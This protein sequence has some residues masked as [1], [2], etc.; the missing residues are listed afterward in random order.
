M[1][2]RAL[3]LWRSLPEAERAR[4]TPLRHAASAE[5]NAVEAVTTVIADRY[6]AAAN[7]LLA[8]QARFELAAPDTADD[9]TAAAAYLD[10]VRRSFGLAVGRPTAPRRSQRLVG[11]WGAFK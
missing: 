6:R 3:A 8:A 5:L 10:A 2:T 7:S 9:E 1:T 11:G 4:S